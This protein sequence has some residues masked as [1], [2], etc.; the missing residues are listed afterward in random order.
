[1]AGKRLELAGKHRANAAS[2]EPLTYLVHHLQRRHAHF[3]FCVSSLFDIRLGQRLCREKNLDR[4]VP[5]DRFIGAR[6]IGLRHRVSFAPATPFL[7]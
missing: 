4:D 2:F 7:T 1:M 5:A 6:R 3:R